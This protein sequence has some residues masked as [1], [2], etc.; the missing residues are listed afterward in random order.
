MTDV[1]RTRPTLIYHFTHIDHLANIARL[2]LLSDSIA[3]ERA[4]ITNEVG[5]QEIKTRRRESLVSAGPEGRV[6]DYVP[7]YFAPNSPMM[8]AISRGNVPTYSEGT[9]PLVYLV[10]DFDEVL[11]EGC[12]VVTTDR[13]AVLRYAKFFEG[14]SGIDDSIDWD[15]MGA[16]WWN[17]TDEEPDRKEK[18]MAECLVHR[19]LPFSLIGEIH[20][21]S[22]ARKAQLVE[23]LGVDYSE[24]IRVTPRWYF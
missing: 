21:R 2:G 20:V 23:A 7:F 15:L 10:A 18:R 12:Q 4:I 1:A 3:Q 22:A 14:D 19:S 5:N 16:T 24:M 13:N 9:S 17:N 6:S 11:A 8:Y